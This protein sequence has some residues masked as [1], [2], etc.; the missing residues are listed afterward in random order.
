LREGRKAES[1]VLDELRKSI[2]CKA[3]VKA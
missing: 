3:A 2:A 1:Q